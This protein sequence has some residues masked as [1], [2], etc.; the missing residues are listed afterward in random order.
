MQAL[1]WLAAW[2][3]FELSF[4]YEKV[5][6]RATGFTTEWKAEEIRLPAL[7]RFPVCRIFRSYIRVRVG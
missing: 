4:I 6:V 2:P 5:K 3:T 1:E 7:S